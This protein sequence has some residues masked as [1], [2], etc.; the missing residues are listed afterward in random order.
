[1]GCFDTVLVDCPNCYATQDAQSK[2]G[3]CAFI[4]IA[5]NKVTGEL[6]SIQKEYSDS[7]SSQ[8]FP[9]T[10]EVLQSIMR[11]VNRHAPFYCN[12]CGTN[13]HVE[14]RKTFTTVAEK[15]EE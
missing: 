11:D 3:P 10:K 13:F 2:S 15:D 8:S 9:V 7:Y 1:M 5:I 4:A 12:N 6:V 14:E